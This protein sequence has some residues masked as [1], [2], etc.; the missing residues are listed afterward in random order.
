[1]K[2]TIITID[3]DL[4]T[5]CGECIPNCPE[6]ALQIIDGKARLIS[7]LFCDGLGAC[8]GHC[9]VGAI[10]FEEREAEPYDERA[11]I[12]NIVRQG[13]EVIRAHLAH[14]AEHGEEEH[15][16]EAIAYLKEHHIPVPEYRPTAPHAFT[17]CP[18]SVARTIE[19]PEAPSPVSTPSALSQWPIQLH[20]VHPEAPF[21][22]EA[23]LLVA[24]DCTAFALGGFHAQLLAGR[25]LLIACPKLDEGQDVYLEKLSHL[26][27]HA[28]PASITV[29]IME[30]P[31]CRGLLYLVEEALKRAG[32]EVPL[33]LAVV[34]IDGELI[35]REEIAL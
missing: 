18:S 19:R 17:G 25:K 30:V 3:E 9:P 24:A 21:F 7:D 6:G 33:S 31:C 10:S 5:G 16:S 22:R 4:C 14:L 35:S 29:A 23:H 8:I 27:A 28:R 13:P 1:M 15:L 26:F 20:L 11:V 32:T 12:A 2:R 34:S